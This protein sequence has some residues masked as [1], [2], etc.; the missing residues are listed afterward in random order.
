MITVYTDGSCLKNPNGPGGWAFLV[1]GLEKRWEVSGG[2]PSTTNNR[3][4]LEAV[5]Q[6]LEFLSNTNDNISIYTDSKYVINGITEWIHNWIRKNW[7]NV[8]NSDL[9][10]KL[11]KLN[12]DKVE[13]KW[14]KGHSGNIYN[15]RVDKLAKIE[16][17]YFN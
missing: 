11:Y 6:T 16:A 1:L 13:W 3:M 10:K 7:K 2:N 15:D 5:I 14:V 17:E 4:E 8:K 12:D 9:W